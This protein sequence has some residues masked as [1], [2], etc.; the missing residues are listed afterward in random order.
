MSQCKVTT[1]PTRAMS[2][3]Q[4]RQKCRCLGFS[5]NLLP[6]LFRQESNIEAEYTTLLGANY[7]QKTN[8]NAGEYCDENMTNTEIITYRLHIANSLSN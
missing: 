8:D 6:V 5:K 1:E 7:I 3:W 2:F 4:M